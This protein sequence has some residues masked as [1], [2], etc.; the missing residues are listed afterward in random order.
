MGLFSRNE[1]ATGSGRRSTS[2]S[3]QSSESQA[4]DLRGRARR[5][6]I[7]ALALVLAAVIVVPM[8][9]DSSV[10]PEQ[11]STPVVVPAIVPPVTPD[12]NEAQVPVQPDTTASGSLATSPET[13]TTDS[14]AGNAGN[15]TTPSTSPNSGTASSLEPSQ[16]APVPEPAVEPKPKPKPVEKP[17]AK[18]DPKPAADRTDD[19]SVA[20]ALLE[21]RSP[22][23]KAA[24]P[25]S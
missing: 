10:P 20:M 25:A 8:L 17:V 24:A 14:L 18:P 7:G 12:V 9:F 5:R 19:G 23:K 4:S 2:R 21:G 15:A 3:S 11:V 1:S 22:E 16:P 6:L 13:G